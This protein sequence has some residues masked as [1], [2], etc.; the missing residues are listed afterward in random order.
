[1]SHLSLTMDFT[2]SQTISKSLKIKLLIVFTNI[3]HKTLHSYN[4]LFS[5]SK[6]VSNGSKHPH[7]Y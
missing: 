7:I 1:M 4:K 6:G 3:F 5:S 2:R